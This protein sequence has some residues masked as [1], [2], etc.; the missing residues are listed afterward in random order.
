M[1]A[2]SEKKEAAGLGLRRGALRA[3]S[4]GDAGGGALAG[5]RA[6]EGAQTEPRWRRT[7]QS[8]TQRKWA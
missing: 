5:R 3:A 4:G 6:D 8:G 7:G 2:N 1:R